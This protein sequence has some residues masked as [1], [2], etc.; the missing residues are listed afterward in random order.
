MG[1]DDCKVMVHDQVY[2]Y[3]G[4]DDCMAIVYT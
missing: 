1:I 4:I 3:V 2:R